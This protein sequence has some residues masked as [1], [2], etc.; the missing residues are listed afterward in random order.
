MKKEI[1]CHESVQ[2]I[3]PCA[4]KTEEKKWQKKGSN[5]KTKESGYFFCYF[6]NK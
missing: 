3:G 4:L 6:G 5:K 1:I 2:I